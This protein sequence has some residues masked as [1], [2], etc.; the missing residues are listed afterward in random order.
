MPAEEREYTVRE[1][2][3]LRDHVVRQCN[4]LAE[5]MER[6]ENGDILYGEDMDRRRSAMSFPM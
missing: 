2:A 6:D 1:L 4:E 5:E 3:I